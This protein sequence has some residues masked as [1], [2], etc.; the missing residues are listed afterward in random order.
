MEVSGSRS[1]TSVTLC[2]Q[3][4]SAPAQLPHRPPIAP[5]PP[6]G[7][8]G[9][10]QA[11]S[12]VGTN[13]SMGPCSCLRAQVMVWALL[14]HDTSLTLAEPAGVLAAATTASS[15][16]GRTVW[17]KVSTCSGGGVADYAIK[18]DYFTHL[19]NP[20][21]ATCTSGFALVPIV[22][23]IGEEGQ[24]MQF[25]SLRDYVEWRMDLEKRYTSISIRTR[26]HTHALTHAHTHA[27]ARTH[28]HTHTSGR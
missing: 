3:W 27:R 25:N 20:Q 28:T 19:A 1:S 18:R 10:S 7:S 13:H 15:A 12:G 16:G 24:L 23:A 5:A 21:P 9:S 8:Q 2:R 11:C 22:R 17:R 6:A 14:A 26:T 4:A